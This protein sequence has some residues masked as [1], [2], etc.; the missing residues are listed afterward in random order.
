LLWF[1]THMTVGWTRW[2]WCS[3]FEYWFSLL[4]KIYCFM[5]KFGQNDDKLRLVVPWWI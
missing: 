1:F 4:H 3:S 2:K 5:A